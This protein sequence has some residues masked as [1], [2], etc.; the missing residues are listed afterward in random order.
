MATAQ[1][2]LKA[3]QA[4]K[5]AAQQ[6]KMSSAAAAAGKGR[7]RGDSPNVPGRPKVKPRQKPRS[8]TT[9]IMKPSDKKKK[10]T[11]R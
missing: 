4:K 5:K 11:K 6:K 2:S 7:K 1:Q 10:P 3:Q 9:A 8:V